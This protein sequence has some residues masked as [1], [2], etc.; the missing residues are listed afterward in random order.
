MTNEKKKIE[1]NAFTV[2]EAVNALINSLKEAN[3]EFDYSTC[4]F[5]YHLDIGMLVQ[6]EIDDIP[7]F[8]VDTAWLFD[9]SS[10]DWMVSSIE[11]RVEKPGYV[12]V[13]LLEVEI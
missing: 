4:T 13:F 3:Y 1:S 6:F 10:F 8:P 7:N 12:V 2:A 5:K 9:A 11:P